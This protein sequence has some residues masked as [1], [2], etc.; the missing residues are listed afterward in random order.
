MLSIWLTYFV[1]YLEDKVK[2][3]RRVDTICY[4]YEQQLFQYELKPYA[5]NCLLPISTYVLICTE[6]RV[7]LN[8]V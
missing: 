4:K 6:Y 8:I 1:T 5:V 7:R 3:Y 2:S